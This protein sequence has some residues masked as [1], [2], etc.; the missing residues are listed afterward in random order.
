MS[1]LLLLLAANVPP[2]PSPTPAVPIEVL[3]SPAQEIRRDFQEPLTCLPVP[4]EL[5]HPVSGELQELLKENHGV[6]GAGKV[7]GIWRKGPAPGEG[8]LFLF[9][10]DRL[11]QSFTLRYDPNRKSPG[12]AFSLAGEGEY[13][14]LTWRDEGFAVYAGPDLLANFFA[15]EYSFASRPAVVGRDVVAWCPTLA[16]SWEVPDDPP[17]LCYQQP[18]AGGK[19]E[20]L[21][22]VDAQLW[23]K[24]SKGKRS[25]LLGDLQVELAVRQDRRLYVVGKALADVYLLR[26]SGSVEKHFFLPWALKSFGESDEYLQ[27]SLAEAERVFK[28]KVLQDSQRAQDLYDASKPPRQLKALRV[29]FSHALIARAFA[30]D[31]DLVLTTHTGGKPADAL[32]WLADNGQRSRC[33]L[34]GDLLEKGAAGDPR[35]KASAYPRIAVTTDRLWLLSPPGYFLW[36]ELERFWEEAQKKEKKAKP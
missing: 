8:Q 13:V 24:V 29:S 10:G 34:L 3:S 23:K 15:P 11:Q 18:L 21:L 20:P 22:T 5:L 9:Q 2:T 31:K 19:P 25:N 16:R 30:K 1:F 17:T 32:L 28:E 7:L 35:A 33:F 12:P 6:D 14:F 36:E 4:Q 27:A 26:P